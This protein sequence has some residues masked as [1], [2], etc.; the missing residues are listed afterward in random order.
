MSSSIGGGSQGV[1]PPSQP[2]NADENLTPTE[3]SSY[4]AGQGPG[5]SGYNDGV[6]SDATIKPSGKASLGD[7]KS[8]FITAAEKGGSSAALGVKAYNQFIE[9]FES[10]AVTQMQQ[11]SNN[12]IQQEQDEQAE[13]N[14]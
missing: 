8:A 11:T 6:G 10:S 3:S 4:N 9:L 5:Q 1:N 14:Q 7:L 12:A 2:P 13:G